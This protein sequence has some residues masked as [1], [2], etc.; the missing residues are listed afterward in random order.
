[1]LPNIVGPIL[2]AAQQAQNVSQVQ[3]NERA[4]QATADRAQAKAVEAAGGSVGTSDA[5]SQVDAE[6]A[7]AGSQGR[8][9]HSQPEE[10]TQEKE[11]SK[12]V[13]LDE[14]GNPHLDIKA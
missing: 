9:S 8:A 14:D 4:Q 12:G 11:D 10:D 2:Q 7:G 13:T 1:M 5:D 3:D 6:T